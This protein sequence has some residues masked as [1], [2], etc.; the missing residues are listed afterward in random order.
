M[1]ELS[2]NFDVYHAGPKVIDG[3]YVGNGGRVLLVAT[4][5]E[6][7]KEAQEKVYEGLNKFEWR[8]FFYRKDIGWR[9][10]K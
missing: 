6:T 8:Q 3:Q 1:D 5:A 10:F 7:L 2:R 4:K 9:T